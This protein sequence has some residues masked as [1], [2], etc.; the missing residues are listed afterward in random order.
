M[1]GKM[2]ADVKIKCPVRNNYPGRCSSVS[3]GRGGDGEI[4]QRCVKRQLWVRVE[5][6][7][8]SGS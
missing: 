1:D 6:E 5:R 2:I 7:R 4:E 8:E 3:W